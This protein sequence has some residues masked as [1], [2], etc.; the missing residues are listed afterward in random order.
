MNKPWIISLAIPTLLLSAGCGIYSFSGSTLPPHI[1]TVAV[2]LFEN[3]TPEFGIDQSLTDGIIEAISQDNTL[4]I[5]DPDN[6][7]SII[8]GAIV[9]IED[10]ADTY[11]QA[12]QA[13]A[14]RVTI[15]VKASFTDRKDRK[16]F[17]DETLT[18]WGRYDNS[19][20]SREEGLREAIRKLG[21]DIINRSVS[22]W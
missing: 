10:R 3:R 9:R 6:A 1:R 17:W 21:E 12:E 8:E 4:K 19:E 18:Q 15:T 14:Y 16:V 13:S 20:T 5:S 22:G 7:D 2:P 11:D